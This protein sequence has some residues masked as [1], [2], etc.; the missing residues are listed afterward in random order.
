MMVNNIPGFSRNNFN[1]N[2][3][4]AAK[5]LK[6]ETRGHQNNDEEDR[7]KGSIILPYFRLKKLIK[8]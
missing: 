7:H 5:S 2:A 8:I 4:I 1:Y 6:K 3:P